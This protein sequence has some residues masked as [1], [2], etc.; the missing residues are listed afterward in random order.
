MNDNKPVFAPSDFVA[1][2]NQ[3]LEFAYPYVIVEGELANLKVSRGKWLYFDIKDESASVKC[4]GTVYMLPG[5]LED[6]MKI[7]VTAQ[8]RLH[9]L[10]NFSLNIQSVTPTGEGSIKRAADLL[11]QKLLAEGLFDPARKRSLPYPPSRIGLITSGESAAYRDFVKVLEARWGGL[12]VLH[13][14]AQVQGQQAVVDIVRAIEHMNQLSNPPEALVI[15]RGGG[16]IDDLAAFSSEQITRAVAGSRIPTLVA[17]GHEIDI[18]LAELAADMRASTPSNAAE[19]LVPDKAAELI[20]IRKLR[21]EMDRSVDS[22]LVSEQKLAAELH[23]GLAT[24]LDN[25]LRRTVESVDLRRQILSAF[26][27]T[28]ALR[29]GYAVVRHNGSVIKSVKTLAPRDNIDIEFQD[30]IIS[31]KINP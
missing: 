12:T 13:H 5:P 10:Y 19:L 29:R 31:A 6:G 18:S 25:C 27:P 17:I 1:V 21:Q 4:F 23:A 24:E 14:E 11:Q 22:M 7:R 2:L 26:N 20:A 16:S 8:P 15:T 3:T 9:P 30:G 28:A